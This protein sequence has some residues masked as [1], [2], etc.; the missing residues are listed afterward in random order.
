MDPGSSPGG[1]CQGRPLP[2]EI[3][4]SAARAA[5][6]RNG[7]R[8]RCQPPLSGILP[9]AA[10][11]PSSRSASLAIG[12]PQNDACG[13]VRSYPAMV[14][15]APFRGPAAPGKPFII[16]SCVCRNSRCPSDGLHFLSWSGSPQLVGIAAFRDQVTGP[17]PRRS[18]PFF[19]GWSCNLPSCPG[20][21]SSPS[22]DDWKLS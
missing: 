17:L 14:W 16:S 13:A 21:P 19:S 9:V 7:G 11:L 22:S 4:R 6:T 1:R 8:H 18:V 15:S 12:G 5:R 3:R 10:R 20:G 2:P